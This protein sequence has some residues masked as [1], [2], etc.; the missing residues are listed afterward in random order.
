MQKSINGKYSLLLTRLRRECNLIRYQKNGRELF[1]IKEKL[2]WDRASFGERSSLVRRNPFVACNVGCRHRHCPDSGICDC[3]LFR[4]FSLFSLDVNRKVGLLLLLFLQTCALG[5]CTGLSNIESPST[6]ITY[7]ACLASFKRQL[8]D[9]L[10]A[11]IIAYDLMLR[12]SSER[13]FID[14]T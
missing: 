11:A 2:W 10:F 14:H 12:R 6:I 4:T 9:Q 1:K 13:F 5:K 8:C 3:H 7:R